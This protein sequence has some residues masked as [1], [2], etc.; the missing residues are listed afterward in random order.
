MDDVKCPLYKFAMP[1]TFI[2][3][4]NLHLASTKQNML[5][6]SVFMLATGTE[7][8]TKPYTIYSPGINTLITLIVKTTVVLLLVA[9]QQMKKKL[10]K[11]RNKKRGVSNTT[12]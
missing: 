8:F 4:R 5:R 7:H 10:Q 1:P 11:G 2:C 12:K 9:L 6:A 3:A